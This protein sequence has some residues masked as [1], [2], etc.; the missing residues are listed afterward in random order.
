MTNPITISLYLYLLITYSLGIGVQVEN[1][2]TTGRF[3]IVDL[4]LFICSPLNLLPMLLIRLVS[5]VVDVDKAIF[6]KND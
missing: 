3:C 4:I 5:Y 6:E 1:F 2:K